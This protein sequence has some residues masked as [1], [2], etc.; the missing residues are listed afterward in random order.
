[1]LLFFV[2]AMLAEK[3]AAADLRWAVRFDRS[4]DLV[5]VLLGPGY[6]VAGSFPDRIG[7]VELAARL[8]L[9]G[10]DHIAVVATIADFDV[11]VDCMRN[12][13]CDGHFGRIYF[14]WTDVLPSLVGRE[15]R[16]ASLS[17]PVAVAAVSTSAAADV[18][19]ALMR[20]PSRGPVVP[21]HDAAV[22]LVVL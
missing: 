2:L 20:P 11:V 9:P 22:H 8:E 10:R 6:G 14:G 21:P 19:A 16:R 18:A 12:A 1:M 13:A 7:V 15:L 17:G 3:R 5:V 4:D